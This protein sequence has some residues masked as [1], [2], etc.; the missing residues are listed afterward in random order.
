[1]S[2]FIYK[3]QKGDPDKLINQT[4]GWHS[5]NFKLNDKN[6]IQFKFAQELQKHIFQTFQALG[7]KTENQNI[8]VLKCGYN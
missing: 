4:G 3:L 2:E 7:W 1:M 6:S 5:K 8:R